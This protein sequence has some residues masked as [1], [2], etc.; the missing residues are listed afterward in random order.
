MFEEGADIVDAG[1]ESTRPGKRDPVTASE[2]IDRIL[3]VLQGV[4]HRRPGSI[5]SIDT[6]HAETAAEALR[7]GVEIVNDV[8]GLQ[9]DGKMARVCAEAGC[10]VVL[11]HTRGRPEDWHALPPMEPNQLQ[12][13]LQVRLNR[14]VRAGIQPEHLVLDPGFEPGTFCV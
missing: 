12:R 13:E 2:E 8:S 7:A 1:G 9:W 14:A 4:L 10:G 3:P 11:M 5:L 6:Y